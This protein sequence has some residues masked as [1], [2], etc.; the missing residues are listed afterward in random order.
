MTERQ[1]RNDR[2]ARRVGYTGGAINL[3]LAL[4]KATGG[5]LFHSQALIA[6]AVDSTSDLFTDIVAIFTIRVGRKPVDADHPYGHG[7]FESL[8]SMVIAAMLFVA[9]GILASNAIHALV[10]GREFDVGWPAAV[11]AA[12]SVTTKEWLFRWTKSAARTTRSPALRANAYHHRSDAFSSMTVVIGV[13]GSVLIPGAT[14]LDSLASIA[15]SGFIVATG[16]RIGRQAI[17]E[18]TD[19]EQNPELVGEL[20]ELAL[21]VGPVEDAHRIRTRRYGSLLYVDMDIE[22]APELTVEEGHRIT[23]DVKDLILAQY[24]YIADALIHL[25]PEGSRREG[26]GPVR[27]AA[28]EG[29]PHESERSSR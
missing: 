13:G 11:I 7:R 24:D 22:V 16:V 10:A 6:D 23:H 1:E 2:L 25:E 12:V 20:G 21:T 8:G 19:M 27:G 29:V 3:A 17:H 9:A 5:V 4:V 18:L 28:D 15:V 14:F 26:E